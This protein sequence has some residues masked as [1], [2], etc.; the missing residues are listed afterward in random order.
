MTFAVFIYSP[1]HR[2]YFYFCQNADKRIPAWEF[3]TIVALAS[4]LFSIGIE[5]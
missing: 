2:A 3:G 1:S 5:T 4:S